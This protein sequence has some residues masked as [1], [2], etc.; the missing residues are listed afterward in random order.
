MA[1]A[2]ERACGVTCV[3]RVAR[4]QATQQ[5]ASVHGAGLI[6]QQEAANWD[7]GMAVHASAVAAISA[8]LRA[9]AAREAADA[10]HRREAEA[11]TPKAVAAAKPAPPWRPWPRRRLR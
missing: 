8:A 7:H 9:A 3:L 11:A 2:C 6:A 1:R 10:R 5:N 4:D